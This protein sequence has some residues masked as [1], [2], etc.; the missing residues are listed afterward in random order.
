MHDALNVRVYFHHIPKTAGTSLREY[1]L[2]R[3]GEHNV[4]PLL[5]YGTMRDAMR[6]YSRFAVI[7]GHLQV[8]P[9]DTLPDDRTSITLLR[10]PVDRALSAFYF[11]RNTYTGGRRNPAAAHADL[12]TWLASRSREEAIDS[13]NGHLAFLWPLGSTISI[14][15]GL[16]ER[17]VAAKRALDAFDVIGLQS[18]MAETFAIV[19]WKLGWTPP[20]DM[21]HFN[22][23]TGRTSLSDLSPSIARE[24]EGLLAP[25]IE[26]LEYA[27][28]LFEAQR[29]KALRA[30]A[31]S[32]ALRG[33]GVASGTTSSIASPDVTAANAA[34]IAAQARPAPGPETNTAAVD[35][36]RTDVRIES[37]T[38]R[39]EISEAVHLQVGEPAVLTVRI[40]AERPVSD[41]NIGFSI[42]DDID[43]LMF[44]TNMRAL[45]ERI[46][47]SP[48]RYH[49]TFRTQNALGLGRYWISV[50]LHEGDSY[51]D[52]CLDNVERA[53][54][55]EVV[56]RLSEYFE[57]RVRLHVEAAVRPTGEGGSVDVTPLDT[58]GHE[59]FV[60]LAT[61][62]PT[63]S[64]F[65]ARLEPTVLPPRIAR[66]TEAMLKLRIANTGRANWG[67]YG[68]CAV[69]VSYHWYDESGLCVDFD[70]LRTSLPRDIGGGEE[71]EL[72]C[73]LRA[74]E[75]AGRMR[76]VWTLV[77]EG[78]AWFNDRNPSACCEWPVEVA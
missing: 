37:V 19:A 9:G 47:V 10:D 13:L 75:R 8:L 3:V 35:I 36:W 78:V 60:L 73:F 1:L 48:G 52:G 72:P 31:L 77:Q 25:D 56:D 63:L 67:A 68:K 33:S 32:N 23:T 18:S 71:I 55:F 7:A 44:A 51:I 42:R 6:E 15:P 45:G 58:P 66:A 40:V 24:L 34:A 61:R 46:A 11:L 50:T 74:P 16:H 14:K 49:A 5:R 53:C 41:L 64:E 29:L 28:S 21:L 27:S 4:A 30:A 43:S 65:S 62:N 76:L 22:R 2:A 17:V 20:D 39:G 26:I 38:V 12:P 70:G 69:F 59:K 54:S 57:G